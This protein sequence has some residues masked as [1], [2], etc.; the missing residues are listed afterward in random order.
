MKVVGLS[1]KACAGKNFVADIFLEKGFEL[2][3][4]DKLGHIA[5]K[6]KKD[7]IVRAFSDFDILNKNNEIDRKKLGNIVFSNKKKLRLLES[8]VHPEIKLM[9]IDIINNTSKNVILNAAILQR[10]KLVEL[11]DNII[12]VKASLLLRFKRSK[13]RDKRN[14]IWFLIRE[15]AQLDINIKKL[16]REKEVYVI[17]NNLSNSEI[18]R[19]IVKYCDIFID[20]K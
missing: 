13:K 10:G 3:D 8:I 7:E 20:G 19:Q 5:L 9:C 16:K 11:C 12:F 15:F 14:F 6:N 18:Y 2:I 17:D 1:G 4:V